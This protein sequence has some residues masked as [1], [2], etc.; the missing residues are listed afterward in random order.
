MAKCFSC[1]KDNFKLH[2]IDDH[3]NKKGFRYELYDP[4]SENYHDQKRCK[5][6]EAKR[7]AAKAKKEEEEK[8][9][10]R[11]IHKKA[12]WDKTEFF[13]EPKHQELFVKKLCSCSPD[14]IFPTRL[15]KPI[16]Y[17]STTKLMRIDYTYWCSFCGYYLTRDQIETHFNE[18]AK[19]WTG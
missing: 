7:K 11:I 5:E 18:Y 9:I 6:V 12:G 15:E 17:F 4:L 13:Y 8:L 19:Q 2:K 3:Q 16:Y 1:G 10:P 14:Q